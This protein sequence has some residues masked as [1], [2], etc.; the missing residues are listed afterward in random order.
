MTVGGNAETPSPVALVFLGVWAL[1]VAAGAWFLLRGAIRVMKSQRTGFRF[2]LAD[3]LVVVFGLA[4]SV[5]AFTAIC[6]AESLLEPGGG[7]RAGFRVRA[8][9]FLVLMLAQ[10]SGGLTGCVAANPVDRPNRLPWFLSAAVIVGYSC[11]AVLLAVLA[12]LP[13]VWGL[14]WLLIDFERLVMKQGRDE[15]ASRS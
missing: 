14:V 7:L 8:G 1:A 3:L 5:W 4:L 11:F 2:R 10:L 9:V 12:F 13:P 6:R 15:L